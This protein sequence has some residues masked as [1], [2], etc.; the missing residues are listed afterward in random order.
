LYFFIWKLT[1]CY[2]RKLFSE[3]VSVIQY[4]SKNQIKAEKGGLSIRELEVYLLTQSLN[5][6]RIGKIKSG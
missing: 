3:T 5:V 6:E 1:Q 2:I 4:F